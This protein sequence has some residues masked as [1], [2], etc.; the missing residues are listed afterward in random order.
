MAP[1]TREES[2]AWR[3]DLLG[4]STDILPWYLERARELPD[5]S[6][7]AEVGSYRG[8]SVVFLAEAFAKLGK[9][10]VKIWAVDPWAWK[11]EDW[12]AM[13][14]AL[15]PPTSPAAARLIRLVR[16]TS[17]R[18]S[19]M[20]DD[21]ELDWAFLDGEHTDPHPRQDI[22]F[23]VRKVRPGGI[24]SGH[25]Y[26]DPNWPAVKASVDELIPGFVAGRHVDDLRVDGTV[27]SCRVR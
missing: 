26:A 17:E 25:D 18:A 10:E 11:P 7:I 19:L 15:G 13:L 27:W 5:G 20:F 14:A 9:N 22:G 2:E 16:A 6:K 4:W 23:W 24:L 12:P 21:G 1:M 8:R 3:P